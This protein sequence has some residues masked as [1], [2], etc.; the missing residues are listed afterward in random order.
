MS[1][2][3]QQPQATEFALRLATA[4]TTTTT[5]QAQYEACVDFM[6]NHEQEQEALLKRDRKIYLVPIVVAVVSY[7]CFPQT[8]ATF[9]STLETVS[10]GSYTGEL[11]EEI[12][13][14][15]N[16]PVTLTISILFGSLVSMTISTLYSR[17]TDIHQSGVET[18]NE[19]RHMQYLAEALPEPERSM[20]KTKLNMFA[21]QRLRTFFRGDMFTKEQ[22]GVTLTP[23]LLLLRQAQQNFAYED[24]PYMSELYAS[25]AR[26]KDTWTKYSS[27]YQRNFTPAHYANLMAQAMTLLLIY[28]W[29]TDDTSLLQAHEFELRVAWSILLST[30]ASLAAIIVDL[31]TPISNIITMVRKYNVD[32]DEMISYT[33]AKDLPTERES[34]IP[35]RIDAIDRLRESGK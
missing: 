19:L 12:R 27:A 1:N 25:C 32:M 3:Q 7:A 35:M 26:L 11:S 33:L 5:E 17:Q 8:Q 2:S 22:R 15:I 14:L 16:G 29:E 4:P 24:A 20:V 21:L 18:S 6:E 30:M 13:P 34:L 9:H 31:S 10:C 28:L 23:L